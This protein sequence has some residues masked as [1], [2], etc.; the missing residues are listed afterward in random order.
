M[1][2][3]IVEISLEEQI[4]SKFEVKQKWQSTSRFEFVEPKILPSLGGL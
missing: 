4:L 2:K 1:M 3:T